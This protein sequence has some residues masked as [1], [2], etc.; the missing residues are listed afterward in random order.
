MS[1]AQDDGD[2]EFIT[3]TFRGIQAE[4]DR[5]TWRA[6]ME[7]AGWR[8]SRWSG[9]QGHGVTRWCR[10]T[11]K[12]GRETSPGLEYRVRLL[13]RRMQEMESELAALAARM[14]PAQRLE[15]PTGTTLVIR[16]WENRPAGIARRLR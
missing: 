15:E 6:N 7:G 16:P 3:E 10:L 12:R 5:D 9:M 1:K 4:L 14:I 13:E 11:L 8:F 2:Y